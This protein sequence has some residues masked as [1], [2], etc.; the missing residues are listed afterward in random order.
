MSYVYEPEVEAKPAERRDLPRQAVLL[1]N[2]GT[3]DGPDVLS[4]RR[5]LTEFLADPFVI[6]LPRPLRWLQPWLA[7]FIARRRAPHS[8]EKYR[9]IWTEQGS[10]LRAIMAEQAAALA[11]L[12]PDSWKVLTAMR[13]GRPSIAEAVQTII[14]EGIAELVVV[15]VYPQYSRTTTGTLVQE[16][17]SVLKRAGAHINV[18]ART[19]W[20]DDAGYV[21][22]QAGLIADYAAEQGLS[23]DNAILLFSAHGL[24][25]SYVERGDPY[26]A[27]VKRSIELVTARLGWPVQRTRVAY[28]SRM[29]P[30]AWLEPD[31]EETLA[32]LAAEG[33]RRVLVC[34]ISFAVD[35][36]ETLEEIGLR[37]RQRFESLGGELHRCPAMN[38]SEPFMQV[39]KN[40]VARGS[41]PVTRWKEAALL[42]EPAQRSTP[43]GVDLALGRLFMVGVSLASRVGPGRGPQLV[44]SETDQFR[45]AKKPH[46]EVQNLLAAL[47]LG[48]E[49]PEA[50]VWNTCHRFELYGWLAET[51]KGGP[52]MVSRIRRDL[53]G[54]GDG[55]LQVN[56]LFGADAWH[57]LMRTVIGLNSGLPG[58]KD[59]VEQLRNA[60]QQAERA[61]TAGAR[62]KALVDE[63]AGLARDAQAETTWGRESLG[64]CHA[65]LVQLQR[66]MDLKLANCRHVVIGGSATSRSVLQSL[67]ERFE[68]HERDA[69]L[70]Y[71]AHQGGQTKLLRK[72]IG[73]GRRLRVDSYSTKEVVNAIADAD[74]VYFGID[75]DE[76]VLT[77]EHLRGLRDFTAR[78]LTIVDFN[79]AGSTAGLENLPG[80][81]LLTAKQIE[82][83]VNA[84]ADEVCMQERFPHNLTEAESWIE[85]RAPRGTPS[86]IDLPCARNGPVVN[87]RCAACGRSVLE[88]LALEAVR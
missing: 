7:S 48:G 60:Y 72:V 69:T 35:C 39:L 37:Y 75:R 70:V 3:P 88:L 23:P 46:E 52:C 84:L 78:P 77:D 1:V 16:L 29:G 25:V 34:P 64:Y 41:R 56:V 20:Y 28:Q 81:R 26:A 19:S 4:V 11:K 45:C 66:R 62:L 27:Q 30:G 32:Q 8:A 83:E 63:A 82:A 59:I 57:H 51:G 15:P 31:T 54:D 61:G 6:Q 44:Y 55:S 14:D 36:L 68:V 67:F 42:A 71:R 73:N 38:A 33:E 79:T 65:A 47:R 9:A 86:D 76:P 85:G 74:V 2:V 24:P 53:L 18:T 80:V 43:A 58:D 49:V 5:Y 13:Y 40:L 22:A 21:N 10:P 87:P 12:L 50:L 17:Y